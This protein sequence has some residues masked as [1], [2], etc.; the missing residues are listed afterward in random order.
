MVFMASWVMTLSPDESLGVHWWVLN[1]FL[2]CYLILKIAISQSWEARRH[3]WRK[4][5]QKN[6]NFFIYKIPNLLENIMSS[7]LKILRE[8]PSNSASA[9][10]YT[11]RRSGLSKNGASCRS[12]LLFF[13][14]LI[15]LI[16]L[17]FYTYRRSGLSKMGLLVDLISYY[18]YYL[19]Y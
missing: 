19:Y 4:Q 16:L 10:F 5:R 7:V 12:H 13:L 9:L 8:T 15:L 17:L 1:R 14:L 11:C 3:F 18:S 6:R 2:S